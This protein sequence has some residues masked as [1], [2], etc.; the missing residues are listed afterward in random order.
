MTKQEILEKVLRL[1]DELASTGI[2]KKIF[3][4]VETGEVEKVKEVDETF[5]KENQKLYQEIVTFGEEYNKLAD[6]DAT[7]K[8]CWIFGNEDNSKDGVM[9][10]DASKID[11]LS[12]YV[13]SAVFAG[14]D[15]IFYFENYGLDSDI[16]SKN[17]TDAIDEITDDWFSN[18]F[19]D[20]SLVDWIG[21]K[22]E[23]YPNWYEV[24]IA[25]FNG[26]FDFDDE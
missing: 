18:F 8:N 21:E 16:S 10:F 5:K 25:A 17:F 11:V 20:F 14:T 4:A 7:G 19:H 15:E 1:T 23:C 6:D 12:F 2:A 26:E 22:D 9:V 24:L 13:L 3:D